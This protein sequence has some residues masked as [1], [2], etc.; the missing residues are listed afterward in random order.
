MHPLKALRAL[1]R[2]HE[3]NGR[4]IFRDDRPVLVIILIAEDALCHIAVIDE[5]PVQ[6]VSRPPASRG[7]E[8]S[9]LARCGQTETVLRCACQ[10]AAEQNFHT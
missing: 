2:P 3:A 4:Q 9:N 10:L 6:S 1:D 5:R 7:F 8:A